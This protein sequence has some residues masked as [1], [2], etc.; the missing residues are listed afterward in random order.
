M[1]HTD[2][3]KGKVALLTG[4]ASGIGRATATRLAAEGATVFG[5]DIDGAGL[6]AAA[7]EIAGAGGAVTVRTTDVSDVA[8]CRAAVDACVAAHGGIDILGNIA[9]IARSHH[10]ADVT[11]AEWDL[12]NGVNVKGVFFLTQA[13][14]PHVLE[15]AARAHALAD[16]RFARGLQLRLELAPGVRHVS[17]ADPRVEVH[18]KDTILLHLGDVAAG[19]ARSVFV[20]IEA[21]G[22][23]SPANPAPLGVSG[24]GG[25]GGGWG[26]D[27]IHT[28]CEHP[29]DWGNANRGC[30]TLPSQPTPRQPVQVGSAA[31]GNLPTSVATAFVEVT[32]ESG[33][34]RSDRADLSLGTSATL[35]PIR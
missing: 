24:W 6:D 16:A 1:I 35:S 23:T 19:D 9:G 27:G 13:A 30:R 29:G 22:D 17:T 11:E 28:V 18:D 8:E 7:T 15:R 20:D 33:A 14:L 25:A 2:R 3:F 21:L 31:T 4:V 5:L 34:R 12:M 32:D 10:V 26:S